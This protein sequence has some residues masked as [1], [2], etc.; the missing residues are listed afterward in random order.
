MHNKQ[1][2]PRAVIASGSGGTV[3][4]NIGQ[5]LHITYKGAKGTVAQGVQQP[6]EIATV[7]EVDDHHISL[8][9]HAYPNPTTEYLTLNIGISELSTI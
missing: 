6:Y 1:P 2:P 3:A 8:N 4:F 5:I 7:F 9:I